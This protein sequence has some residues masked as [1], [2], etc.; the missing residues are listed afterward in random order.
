MSFMRALCSSY[1]RIPFIHGL[2]VLEVEEGINITCML[3]IYGVKNARQDND[4]VER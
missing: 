3:Y 4:N 1:S 2:D